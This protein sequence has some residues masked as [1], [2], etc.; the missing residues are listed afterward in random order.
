[1]LSRLLILP[2]SEVSTAD[3]DAVKPVVLRWTF[4]AD[5]GRGKPS[6]QAI[7]T[8]KVAG[9]P[10]RKPRTRTAHCGPVADN[11]QEHRVI[12]PVI[13]SSICRHR[14]LLWNENFVANLSQ[15]L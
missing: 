2:L 7:C 11:G 10:T 14:Q 9:L 3:P 12:G 5:H 13:Y 1:M 6:D 4:E 8:T 15:K